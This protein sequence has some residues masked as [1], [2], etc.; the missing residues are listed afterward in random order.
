MSESMAGEV[1]NNESIMN[2]EKIMNKETV[3]NEKIMSNGK[4]AFASADWQ[5]K[6]QYMNDYDNLARLYGIRLVDYAEGYARMEMELMPIHLNSQG[7]IHGGWSSGLL[8][9]AGVKA[10]RS[11]GRDVRV[12][13]LSMNYYRGAQSGR[14]QIMAREKYRSANLATYAVEVRREDGRMMVDGM[15]TCELLA[16]EYRVH[17]RPLPVA[18]RVAAHESPVWPDTRAGLRDEVAGL[19]SC[20][21]GSDWDMKA[22]YM[23]E[24]ENF[25]YAENMEVTKC[26]PGYC[27]CQLPLLER[28]RDP[29][30]RVEP[31]WIAALMDPL[32][33][34]PSLMGGEFSVTAQMTVHFFDLNAVG[35][36]YGEGHEKSRGEQFG[37]CVGDILDA[38]GKLLASATCTMYLRHN[39]INF[40][41]EYPLN[42]PDGL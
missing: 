25:Y 18:E 16:E 33:G 14:L 28:H 15:V 10:A 40:R 19:R 5:Q 31:A 23:N 39:E 4:I 2:N 37:V 20:F 8:V 27:R 7:S 9:T 1:M 29:W 22:E 3:N 6:I 24:N 30:G 38:E 26:G 32:I 17:E 42:Y 41:R 21:S 11:Y 36:L 12:S 35:G 34:K 13:E